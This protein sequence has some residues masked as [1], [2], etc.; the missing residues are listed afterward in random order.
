MPIP[1]VMREMGCCLAGPSCTV[2]PRGWAEGLGCDLGPAPL[3]TLSE[4]RDARASD[5]DTSPPPAGSVFP[6]S[7]P[8]TA[9]GTLALPQRVGASA[10][11]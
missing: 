5:L 3:V 1:G 11:G 6:R 9:G 8:T 7:S 10:W 4:P 2:R